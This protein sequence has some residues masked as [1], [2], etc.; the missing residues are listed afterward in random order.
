MAKSNGS[1]GGA[2]ASSPIEVEVCMRFVIAAG[3]L[4]LAVGCATSGQSAENWRRADGTPTDLE[5]LKTDQGKCLGR[6]GVASPASRSPMQA[7]RDDMID[8]MRMKGWVKK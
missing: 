1:S 3:I 2:V 7:T 8:C 6:A 5:Q 4:V